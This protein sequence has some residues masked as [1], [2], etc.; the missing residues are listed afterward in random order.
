MYVGKGE[1]PN[2]KFNTLKAILFIFTLCCCVKSQAQ[3]SEGE[4][5]SDSLIRAG[6]SNLGRAGFDSTS[7]NQFYIQDKRKASFRLNIGAWTTPRYNHITRSNTPDSVDTNVKGY[8]I[9]RTRIYFTGKFTDKF[10]FALVTNISADGTFNLQQ[11]YL[12]WTINE[13]FILSLGNQF[14]ASSRED[15]MDPANILSMQC[16]ANDEVFALGTSFGALLYSRPK[17]HMRWWVSLSNGLYGWNRE[18]TQ[19]NQS[20]YM[21]GGRYEYALRGNDWTIWDDLVGRRGRTKDILFGTAVNYLKQ[22]VGQLKN[23]AAQVNLDVT[24]NGDG[25]QVLVAGVWTGQFPDEAKNFNQYGLY[26]Q[27]GY[28]ISRIFQVYGRYDMVA[29]GGAPGSPELYSAPGAGINIYPFNFTNKWKFTLEY[30]RLYSVMNQT[31]VAPDLSLGFVES[32]FYGQH[33]VRFQMQFGF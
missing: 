26:A 21:I 18:I 29:S 7:F 19:S 33:S 5:L 23:R 28:F 12:T 10:N 27:G 8:N 11:A 9:N 25:Y 4:I 22:T 14:V 1:S 31:I 3:I 20:D 6:Y 24:F 30:N 17:N 32:D 13:R 15:W 16:S 2:W